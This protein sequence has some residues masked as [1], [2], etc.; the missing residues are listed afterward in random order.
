[1]SGIRF[2]RKENCKRYEGFILF[3]FWVY[4]IEINIF[5]I[6]KLDYGK[7]I[8]KIKIWLEFVGGGGGIIVYFYFLVVNI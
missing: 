2:W 4:I 5:G 3:Y 7:I 1:M 8:F 6:F